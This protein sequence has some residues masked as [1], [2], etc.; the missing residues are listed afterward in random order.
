MRKAIFT[1]LFL[2][3]YA[4][5][6]LAQTATVNG[7]TYEAV[8]NAEDVITGAQVTAFTTDLPAAVTIPSTVELDGTAYNV[9][10]VKDHAFKENTVMTSIT[11][12]STVTTI[13]EWAFEASALTEID[14]TASTITMIS[15]GA[16]FNC[17]SLTSVKLPETLTDIDANAFQNCSALENI[18]LPSQLFGIGSSAF[19]STGLKNVFFPKTVKQIGN[20]AFKSTQL[21]N[22]V[23]PNFLEKI[24]D[25]A[26]A[27]T[28]ITEVVIPS[29]V[30]SLGQSAFYKCETLKTATINANVELPF[31]LFRDGGLTD[32]YLASATQVTIAASKYPVPNNTAIHVAPSLADAY[33][34]AID[35]SGSE[36]CTVDS[37]IKFTFNDD[38]EYIPFASLFNVDFSSTGLSAF[39]GALN[40]AATQFEM[41]PVTAVPAQNGVLVKGEKGQTYE[42]NIVDAAERAEAF[43]GNKLISNVDGLYLT[44]VSPVT[45]LV[46]GNDV[47]NSLSENVWLEAG[48]A[49]LFNEDGISSVPAE[50]VSLVLKGSS[51]KIE[52]ISEATQNADGAYYTIGGVKVQNPTKGL[53]IHNGKKIVVR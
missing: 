41:E 51:T 34:T 36:N 32:L 50:G 38:E 42:A 48:K 27:Y 10:S 8:K 11:L 6:S 1:L 52:G 5:T 53:Y 28:P 44:G 35:A 25:E 43:N 46:L 31:L 9:T 19:E 2:G 12:P 37:K 3:A 40:A 30:T 14:F 22:P 47:F 20:Y 18:V 15:Q 21:T 26:F 33:K 23:L 17:K 45:D 16:F 39:V 4:G 13:G 7:V 24:G 49:Y 29:T